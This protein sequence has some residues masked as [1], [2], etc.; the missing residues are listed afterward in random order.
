MLLSVLVCHRLSLHAQ[1]LL[2][3]WVNDELFG[4]GMPG[5]LPG[6]LVSEALLVVLVV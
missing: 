6:E 5:E 3:G 1:V 4:N 2:E